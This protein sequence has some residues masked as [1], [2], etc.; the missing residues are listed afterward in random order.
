ME[1]QRDLGAIRTVSGATLEGIVVDGAGKGLA[2]VSVTASMKADGLNT[3]KEERTDGEGR[4]RISGLVPAGKVLI[5][6]KSVGWLAP[7]P[8]E[9]T[10]DG[11]GVTIALEPAGSVAGRVVA[12]V[13]PRPV[14]V[15]S[16]QA[17]PKGGAGGAQSGIFGAPAEGPRASF[18]DET[19]KFTLSELGA[20]D[21][22]L[23]VASDGFVPALVDVKLAQG[24]SRDVGDVVLDRGATITGRAIEKRSKAPVPGA[25]VR[26]AKPGLTG[27]MQ[28]IQAMG[29]GGGTP[30][31]L[32]GTDGTFRM[33]GVPPGP[34]LLQ[35]DSERLSP[36]E[37]SVVVEHGIDP[38]PVT[39]ELVE[40][41]VVHGTFRNK[42]GNPVAGAMI[43]PAQGGFPDMGN[44]TMTDASGHYRLENL[45]PGEWTL[46]FARPEEGADGDVGSPMPKF[47]TVAVKVESGETTNVNL[48]PGID[49]IRVRGIVRRG[50]KPVVASGRLVKLGGS[51]ADSSEL[52][53]DDSGAYSATV[54]SAGRYLASIDV[55]GG[56]ARPAGQESR[57]IVE[58]PPNVRE[59][60][61]DLVIPDA[62]LRGRVLDGD[63]GAPVRGAQIFLAPLKE[64]GEYDLDTGSALIRS[65]TD[66]EGRFELSGVA[67]GRHRLGAVQPGYGI[68]IVQEVTVGAEDPPEQQFL[69]LRAHPVTV[70]VVSPQGTPIEGALVLPLLGPQEMI[71]CGQSTRE[72]G[73]ATLRSLP[74]GGVDL[75]VSCSGY[76][77]IVL[78]NI[79]VGADTEGELKAMLEPENVLAVTVQDAG[80]KP[81][82][83]ATIARVA[84]Q[85]GPD[86]TMVL[87]IDAELRNE[88]RSS[89]P[90]GRILI[91]G[92]A[93]GRYRVE[94]AAGE[95]R[96]S[97]KVK[98]EDG[99]PAAVTVALP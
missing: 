72:D 75:A 42:E 5:T 95:K 21:F 44:G 33:G 76:G 94:V 73:V 46:M 12:G 92:L 54:S 87:G 97:V 61:L 22:S 35:A 68:A 38:D 9:V 17:L 8:Q 79:Q 4:F 45:A 85:D 31:V 69:L 47:D 57:I 52:Q 18:S 41:G 26:L 90:D 99:R 48:P 70:R 7:K 86:L 14:P 37:A 29:S 59:T 24:E 50:D 55:A 39:I 63:T 36:G 58:V 43:M 91:G 51:M 23:T 10:V 67:A 40:G 82:Q 98:V 6:A 28:R 20:G 15:F 89:G 78:R 96:T 13:P 81:V 2:G 66:V 27:F 62:T 56:Q 19:G 30:T 11:E 34:Y 32:A 88:P 60:T 65:K 93:A 74:D 71:L 16:V 49:A 83:G 77:V 25:T 80:R 64:N 84:L 1:R 53:T 3:S